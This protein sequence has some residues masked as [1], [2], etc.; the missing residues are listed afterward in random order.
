MNKRLIIL[1]THG[2]PS[3]LETDIE[4]ISGTDVLQWKGMPKALL[5]LSSRPALSWTLDQCRHL[6]QDIVVVTHAHN[7][8]YYER[9]ATSIDLAKANVLNCGV[10][11]GPVADIAFVRRV[12]GWQTGDV[13][14]LSSDYFITGATEHFWSTIAQ[15]GSPFYFTHGF[16]CAPLASVNDEMEVDST[17]LSAIGYFSLLI[18]HLATKV[19]PVRYRRPL[20]DAYI[21]FGVT[22]EHYLQ[23]WSKVN[24]KTTTT[25][26][27][28]TKPSEI[29]IKA[30][31][32]V[33]LMGNPSDGFYGKT[34]SLLISNFW[35]EVT[36]FPQPSGTTIEIIHKPIM[37]PNQFANMNALT[38]GCEQDGYDNG[39]R[40]LLACCKIIQAMKQF[41]TLT[42]KARVALENGDH[43]TLASL[44]TDNFEL[45]RKTYGDAVVGAR[46]LQMVEIVRRHGGHAKFSGSGGAIVVF[47][48]DTASIKP[49]Q[50]ELEKGGFVFIK[51][52][53]IGSQI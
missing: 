24:D 23:H 36:L 52:T 42:D 17:E 45:R 22:L 30:Y 51:L 44:M 3:Q 38:L 6:F 20:E 25:T 10:S 37:D 9:W 26:T 41:G 43:H 8:K 15:P 32:R 19:N 40:L 13:A 50:W 34:M 2:R 33:G 46:N 53:P 11:L 1:A 39:D 47:V 28:T 16:V 14:I 7:Y 27:A 18:N 5:P 12:K 35:A 29:K 49:L 31:A 21:D 4:T 48:R